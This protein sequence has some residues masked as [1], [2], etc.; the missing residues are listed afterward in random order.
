[1][2]AEEIRETLKPFADFAPAI[3][4]AAEIVQAAEEAEGQ[5]IIAQTRKA[6]IEVEIDA[7]VQQHAKAQ[8]RAYD[9][10][11]HLQATLADCE[12]KEKSR[13][14]Q[15]A[16]VNV[17]LSNAQAKLKDIEAEFDKKKAAK[18]AEVDEVQKALDKV[19]RAFEDFKKT[20]AL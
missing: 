5:I 4:K 10:V 15:L 7:A 11:K 13:R 18:Q 2:T 1:M 14:D 17:E 9:A 3:L 16:A 12:A 6:E 20:H 8:T 19:K